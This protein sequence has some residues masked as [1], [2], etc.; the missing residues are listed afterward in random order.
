VLPPATAQLITT[1]P[2]RSLLLSVLLALVTV[3]GALFVGYYS[4]YPVGFWLTS[5]AFA[6]YVT[7]AAA[8]ALAGRSRQH[9]MPQGA[10]A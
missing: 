9:V 5:I 10:P 8:T 4:P 7:T 1:R 2:L 3:W 6:G